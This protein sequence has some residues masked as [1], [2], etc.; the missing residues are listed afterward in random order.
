[1]VTRPVS[2]DDF[3]RLEH[4][5][6]AADRSYNEA[7]TAVDRLLPGV[8]PSLPPPDGVNEQEITPLNEA[9]RVAPAPPSANG[10]RGRLAHLVWRIVAPWLARQE[11]FNAKIVTHLNNNV[12]HQRELVDS[13]TAALRAIE[14]Q[15]ALLATF[16]SHL[17]VY[18][19]QITP[20]SDTKDRS[21]L[22]QVAL[23]DE[24]AINAVAD[25]L[26]RRS[27][28]LEV[29]EVRLAAQVRALDAAYQD[30]RSTVATLNQATF[31]LKLELEGLPARLDA[32]GPIAEGLLGGAP[33]SAGTGPGATGDTPSGGRALDSWK[34]V[35]FEDLFRG[36]REEI[37]KRQ[38]DYLPEFAGAR[39]VLDA[40]CGRGEFLDLLREAGVAARGLD[41]NHEMVEICRA[42]GLV[43]DETDVLSFLLA[44]G[45][46]TL[47]G[48]FA[49]QVIEHLEPEYLLRTL[50][51]AFHALRPGSRI[52]LETINPTC[53][54]AF[55][56]S[57]I[58][59]MT[60]VRPVH[61]ETL[62]YLL[63]ASGF[64][65][66]EIRYRSPLPQT[67]RLQPVTVT[68]STPPVLRETFETLNQNAERLNRRLFSYMDYAAVAV[69]L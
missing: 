26:L 35:G 58:R 6:L 51:A 52:V 56:E 61:P 49:A 53:W 37:R 5:R 59:D 2:Q 65:Q 41:L 17:V 34:Y 14:Q 4:E 43:A 9:W 7:L 11:A 19:Q 50:E 1:M 10:V 8:T 66:V 15:E 42:R 38:T 67:E 16:H 30:I 40:G 60:H 3:A 47:G 24:Q 33:L 27:E 23:I 69:R 55:F 64:Q 62:Q 31:T 68:E 18:L 57:Y 25:E 63:T 48:L 54:T 22:G 13:I 39:D 32:G 46:G 44:T 36:P 45:D 28:I 21:I 20:Y 29:R 12:R